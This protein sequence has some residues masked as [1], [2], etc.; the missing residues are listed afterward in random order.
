VII[1]TN[2][3]SVST[4]NACGIDAVSVFAELWLAIDSRIIQDFTRWDLVLPY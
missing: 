1:F 2:A 4:C 3:D